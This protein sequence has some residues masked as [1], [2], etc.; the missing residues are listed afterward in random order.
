MQ[1]D[2]ILKIV[3]F[4]KS[5]DTLQ[6]S[7]KILDVVNSWI[8]KFPLCS[9]FFSWFWTIHI[10]VV[11]YGNTTKPADRD[12]RFLLRSKIRKIRE[13]NTSWNC[14]KFNIS[15]SWLLKFPFSTFL[16]ISIA[17]FIISSY[18]GSLSP[19]CGESRENF[20]GSWNA[21]DTT[22]YG[23]LTL[24][25]IWGISD[26]RAE[27]SLS[28]SGHIPIVDF[29]SVRIRLRVYRAPLATRE[30]RTLRDRF[31]ASKYII[32]P[33]WRKISIEWILCYTP[34]I[35]VSATLKKVTLIVSTTRIHRHIV[36]S[37]DACTSPTH[38]TKPSAPPAAHGR[39]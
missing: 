27:G 35:G 17:S 33:S 39:I 12:V 15:K 5:E 16:E 6:F 36:S 20:F 30:K 10:S 34:K 18:I 23:K 29:C 31:C 11:L 19:V 4:G 22:H 2:M 37:H 25:W 28:S 14:C 8:L 13:L 26:Y 3:R 32:Y 24:C 38:T 7:M 21:N 9:S 1:L